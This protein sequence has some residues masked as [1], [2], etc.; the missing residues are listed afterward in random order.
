MK[1]TIILFIILILIISSCKKDSATDNLASEKYVLLSSGTWKIIDYKINSISRDSIITKY[2]ENTTFQFKEAS[3][4]AHQMDFRIINLNT[5]SFS[6]KGNMAFETPELTGPV[7]VY[8]QSIFLKKKYYP[9]YFVPADAPPMLFTNLWTWSS[10]G[11]N[12]FKLY[13]SIQIGASTYTTYLLTFQ[14][15]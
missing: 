11:A 15:Q 3:G 14:R 9:D 1:K 6:L 8:M 7:F 4:S 10:S 12:E 2:F 5:D 13:K